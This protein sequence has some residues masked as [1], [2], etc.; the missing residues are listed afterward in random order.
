VGPGWDCVELG[1][2]AGSVARWLLDRVGEAGSVTA[3]DQDTALLADVATRPNARV[4]QGDLATLDYGAACFD[5]A[6]SRSVLMHVPAAD[7]VLEHLVPALR[8]GAA[9][10]FE[11]VDGSPAVEAAAPGSGWDLPAAFRAVMLPWATSW[12]WARR[13]PGRLEALGFVDVEDDVREDLLRGASPAA[14]FWQQTLR[15]VRPTVTEAARAGARRR[16]GGIADDG[17][18]DAMIAL[19]DDPDFAVPYAARHRVS[20]RWPGWGAHDG[21]GPA[22]RG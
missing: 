8:P 11:E 17:A 5:L 6:H 15:T 18:Y 3:V 21:A 14:A 13:L 4:V 10:L 22:P 20:A 16:H 19:L 1:A 7:T 9:V 12:S 2:G